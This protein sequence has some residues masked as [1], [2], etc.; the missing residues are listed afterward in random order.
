M[1]VVDFVRAL[2]CTHP[3]L[4]VLVISG[5]EEAEQEYA[6]L[7]ITFRMKPL[8]PDHLLA[9]VHRLVQSDEVGSTS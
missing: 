6:G 4:P 3:T 8:L 9:T 1:S 7:N 2:R 5:L